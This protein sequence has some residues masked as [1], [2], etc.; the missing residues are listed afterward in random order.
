MAVDIIGY[1]EGLNPKSQEWEV[2]RSVASDRSYIWFGIIGGV[3]CGF[4]KDLFLNNGFTNLPH[5]RGL[6]K[7]VSEQTRF[8][9]TDMVGVNNHNWLTQAEVNM[10]LGIWFKLIPLEN[11][12]AIVSTI[13]PAY[14]K[15][16]Y[17]QV[18]MVFGFKNV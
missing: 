10:C 7:D 15:R 13:I 8:T 5:N 11:Q 2:I 4:D 6:P 9:L 16:M 17:T 12:S 3:R 1:W 14:G 18:R